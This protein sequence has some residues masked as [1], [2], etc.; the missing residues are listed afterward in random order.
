MLWRMWFELSVACLEAGWDMRLCCCTN[1]CLPRDDVQLE[2]PAWNT[3]TVLSGPSRWIS[4]IC[5]HSHAATAS[6]AGLACIPPAAF[7]L[8]P[9]MRTD[10]HACTAP[11]EGTTTSNR[12][13]AEARCRDAST[14]ENQNPVA[15]P[16]FKSQCIDMNIH[17]TQLHV[18]ARLTGI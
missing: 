5:W 14:D 3:S 13:V 10:M 1:R 15:L 12:H 8:W 18:K 9:T 7:M 6:C 17:E 16:H 11:T 2:P 4:Y